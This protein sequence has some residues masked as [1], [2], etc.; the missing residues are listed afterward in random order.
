[1]ESAPI[2]DD[3]EMLDVLRTCCARSTSATIVSNTDTSILS[4]TFSSLS[5]DSLTLDLH[6]AVDQIRVDCPCY[7]A[8]VYEQARYLFT[9]TILDQPA[10]SRITLAMPNQ[11]SMERRTSLRVPVDSR[12]RVTLMKGDDLLPA[13]PQA[14]SL[15]GIN[16]RFDL[17]NDPQ[18]TLGE[19]VTLQLRIDREC[20]EL[21][22]SV[23]RQIGNIYSIVFSHAASEGDVNPPDKLQRVYWQLR[24]DNLRGQVV[25]PEPTAAEQTVEIPVPDPHG[26]SN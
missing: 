2:I 11:M 9:T 12:L 16:I 17:D 3:D 4:A 10:P 14:L 13:E 19:R 25:K 8:F 21:Q 5:R 24:E 22:G 6:D 18:L 20:A 23:R 1:M 26:P 7:L 15:S